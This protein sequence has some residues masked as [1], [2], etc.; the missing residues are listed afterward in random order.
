MG[1]ESRIGRLGNKHKINKKKLK[2]IEL[3]SWKEL[4]SEKYDLNRGIGIEVTILAFTF[5]IF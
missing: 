1:T 2:L 4:G 3:L 5:L